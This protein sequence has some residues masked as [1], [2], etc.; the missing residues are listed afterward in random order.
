MSDFGAREYGVRL[1]LLGPTTPKLWA[2]DVWREV[3]PVLTPLFDSPRGRTTVRMSQEEVADDR[4]PNQRGVRFGPLGWNPK[5]HMKW[6]HA[7][8]VT[9]AQSG[10]WEFVCASAWAPSAGTCERE[11]RPPDGFLAI[12][13][14][15][16]DGMT[17]HDCKFSQSLLIAV[18]KDRLGEDTTAWTE[19][20]VSIGSV[21]SLR[22][23]TKWSPDFYENAIGD[24][25][26]FGAPY[27]LGNYHKEV[28]SPNILLGD[29]QT[30]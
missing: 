15:L 30:F 8:P 7:S 16:C 5:S 1:F 3:V 12:K 23:E 13:N 9:S 4:S 18:A 29:W 24:W 27:K 6:T 10:D 20:A 11:G 28:L 19:F 25:E 17:L 21:L 26:A 22:I 2:W 14:E